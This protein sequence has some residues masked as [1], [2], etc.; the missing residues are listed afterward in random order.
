MDTLRRAARQNSAR[1]AEPPKK[2]PG[3][4]V[5]EMIK[6]ES[7]EKALAEL[8]RLPEKQ[9]HVLLLRVFHGMTLSE[10]S[11]VTGL[12][13]GNVGFIL[14]TALKNLREQLLA[15]ERPVPQN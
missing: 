6:C 3:D 9:R 4:V 10:I 7:C 13:I 15:V 5:E 8:H 12:S 14:H 1:P 11:E 2:E